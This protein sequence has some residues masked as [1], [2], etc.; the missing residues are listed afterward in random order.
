M[1]EKN[2]TTRRRLRQA[3]AALVLLG[4]AAAVTALAG[5]ASSAPPPRPVAAAAGTVAQAPSGEEVY[6][7][8][9]AWCHG[10]QG[11]GTGRAP[12]LAESGAATA[13]FYLR[14]GRM[15]LASPDEEARRGPPAYPPETIDALVEYVSSL[16]TG[17][18]VPSVGSGD[19]YAG[20]ELFVQNC[21]ACHS[22]SGT[23][24]IVTGGQP[25]P[26]L[27]ETDPTQV[28][29]A[30]RIGPGQMPPFGEDHLDE[31]EVDDIVTYVDSL[32]EPQV[33][34]RFALDQYGPI[35]EMLFA[36]VVLVPAVVV[37]ARLLG[38]RAKK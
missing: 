18:P 31:Q 38:K 32:G 7:R 29:E 12:T 17:E 5:G 6:L 34:S 9:C 10:N 1:T 15:P 23:G 3:V 20:R 8:D 35:A 14:T 13:D 25:A 4:A 22:S 11:E 21:A 26:E 33:R 27:F 30:I 28:A 24:V 16:G 2:R 19:L 36:L 37:V